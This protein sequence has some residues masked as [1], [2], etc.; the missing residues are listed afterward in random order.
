MIS[1][2]LYILSLTLD[3]QYTC[4]WLIIIINGSWVKNNYVLFVL[5]KEP[6]MGMCVCLKEITLYI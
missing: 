4:T 2:Q 1:S 3:L 6:N 5:C